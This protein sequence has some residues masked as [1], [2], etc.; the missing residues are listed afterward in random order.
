[1]MGFTV[2]QPVRALWMISSLAFRAE[3]RA[4]VTALLVTMAES[5]NSAFFALGMRA[6]VD[7]AAHRDAAGVVFSLVLLGCNSLIANLAVLMGFALRN[8]LRERTSLAIERHIATLTAGIPGIDHFER[9]E[10][11]KHLDLLREQRKQLGWVHQLAVNTLGN[12]VCLAG[13][14]LLLASVDWLLLVLPLF[15]APALLL[16]G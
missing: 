2:P 11:L 5:A 8:G 3:P 15:G 9:P 13:T 7:G 16:S 14:L 10:Y 4:A 12:A 1:M 6:L